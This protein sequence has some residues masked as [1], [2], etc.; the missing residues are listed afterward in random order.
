[1]SLRVLLFPNV[2][3][4]GSLR[5]PFFPREYQLRV[6]AGPSFLRKNAHAGPCGSPFP[7][8]LDHTMFIK[9]RCV[10]PGA[11]S[12][13]PGRWNNT[14]GLSSKWCVVCPSGLRTCSLA[15]HARTFERISD[16]H[17]AVPVLPIVKLEI[18]LLSVISVM[19][20]HWMKLHWV[21]LWV[22]QKKHHDSDERSIAH[23]QFG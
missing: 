1:M 15:F 2:H 6:P 11:G 14:D 20:S 13:W 17:P 10:T 12:E 16:P 18:T 9:G 8:V 5:V 7:C 23:W 4:V 21:K 22:K 19:R 3:H